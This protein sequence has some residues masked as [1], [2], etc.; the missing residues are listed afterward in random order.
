MKEDD[1]LLLLYKQLDAALEPEEAASLQQ[2]LGDSAENRSLADNIRKIWVA[3]G[4]YQPSFG[5]DLDA[6]F[7][8]IQS[9]I[10][11][12]ENAPS[13]KRIPLGRSLM[14]IAAALAF[15]LVAVW[16]YRTA[17][18]PAPALQKAIASEGPHR[19]IE[20]SDGTK[21]WLRQGSSL[22]FPTRFDGKNREVHVSGEA[23]FDVAHDASHPFRVAIDG[24]QRVEVLG[25]QFNIRATDQ[26]QT[27]VLVRSGKVRFTP[28]P[29]GEGVYLEAGKKAVYDKKA[30]KITLSEPGSFNELAWQTGGL[31]FIRTPLSQ[32]VK[33]LENWYQVSIVLDNPALASCPHT[34]P[35]T[36]QPIGQ[37]LDALAE[38]YQMQLEKTG[39]NSYRLSGGSC[40]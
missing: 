9:R 5:V 17:T 8:N 2:W 21:V 38:T 24:G 20:L 28:E 3:S 10:H 35:L 6:D 25:T 1:Y 40:Q 12:E 15:V 23:Y 34:A 11:T 36:R 29:G 19:L 26:D 39:N 31:E 32:V 18:T 22:E 13:A 30:Q 14:R 4:D 33:D 27:S 7:S 16:G 37:V